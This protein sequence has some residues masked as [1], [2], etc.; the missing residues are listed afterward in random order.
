MSGMAFERI[1]EN[2][3][4]EAMRDGRFDDLAGRGRPIDL[5]DYF[6]LAG[7]RLR[8]TIALERARRG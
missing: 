6:K 8:L 1:A 5:E 2:R 3:I 7:A 4:R